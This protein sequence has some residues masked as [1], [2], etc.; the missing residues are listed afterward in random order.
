M[1]TDFHTFFAQL[2][3][4]HPK[5]SYPEAECSILTSYLNGDVDAQQCATELTKYTNRRLPVNSKL[6][7]WDLLIQVALHFT[8]THE[9]LTLLT[10][11]I[12]SIPASKD[13]G[14]IDWTA[15]TQSFGEA[16]RSFYDGARDSTIDSDNAGAQK[17]TSGQSA[18]SRQWTNINAF[19]ARL[20]H[21]GLLDDSLNGLIL[22]VKTLERA[23]SEAQVRMNLSAAASWLEF[24]SKEIKESAASIGAHSNWAQESEYR[25]DPEVDG[26]RLA[27]WKERLD[28][29]SGLPWVSEEVAAGCERATIAIEQALWERKK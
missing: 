13:T 29:L 1:A 17:P 23:P 9:D 14:G 19:S 18:A 12:F 20:Q 21:A 16:F 10:S 5:A 28:E 26:K 7:I 3:A 25:K 22:I 4:E 11:E 24:V 6:K 8:D 27:L 15:E 2:R